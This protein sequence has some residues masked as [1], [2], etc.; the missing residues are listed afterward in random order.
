MDI[1]VSMVGGPLLLFGEGGIVGRKDMSGLFC[2]FEEDGIE[3]ANGPC[4][5]A[6]GW[7]IVEENTYLVCEVGMES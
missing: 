1:F 7:S 6:V 5:F 4:S 2:R 3:V